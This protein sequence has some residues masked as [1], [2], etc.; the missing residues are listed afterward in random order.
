MKNFNDLSEWG[1]LALAISLQEDDEP[2]YAAAHGN[3]HYGQM[4]DTYG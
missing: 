1:I 4:M 3:D 2:V